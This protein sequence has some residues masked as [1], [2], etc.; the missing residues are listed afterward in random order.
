VTASFEDLV[1]FRGNLTDLTANE[2]LQFDREVAIRTKKLRFSPSDVKLN[3]VAEV[4]E[5]NRI[6]I[7]SLN[8]V[9]DITGV[10]TLRRSLGRIQHYDLMI[11]EV[12]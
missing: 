8:Q 3:N 2:Q 7:P 12:R 10:K 6:S 5:R 4:R 1:Q 9:Y 11:E